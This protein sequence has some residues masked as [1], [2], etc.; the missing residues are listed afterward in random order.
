MCVV[1]TI[2]QGLVGPS[3]A[4]QTLLIDLRDEV[5]GAPVDG[6][7]V[8]LLA[9]TGEVVHSG[10]SDGS[11]RVVLS[12][13]VAG[14][15]VIV[16]TRLGYEMLRSPLLALVEEGSVRVELLIHPQPIG[17]EGLT[18]V[19]E[20][21]DAE[22]LKPLGLSANELGNRWVDREKIDATSMSSR[23]PDI[24][25]WQNIPGINVLEVDTLQKTLLC[26]TLRQQPRDMRN[27]ALP[28]LDGIV[29]SYELAHSLAAQELDAIAVLRPIEA[30]TL[31]GTAASGGAVLFWTRRRRAP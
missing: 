19:T 18:V 28:V 11:G 2:A 15:Y 27:C 23:A 16:A 31:Y 6:A 3:L 7:S 13:S 30:T 20:G 21:R 24:L 1:L 29:I 9:H 22:L 4:A 10:I 14:E 25:R 26:V 12:P 5:S 8:E 17:L